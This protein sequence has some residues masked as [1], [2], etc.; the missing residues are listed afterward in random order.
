MENEN[1]DGKNG[2]K[3]TPT[4]QEAISDAAKANVNAVV[5]VARSAVTSF[6]DVL[7]GERKPRKGKRGSTRKKAKS[8]EPVRKRGK[9]KRSK[10]TRK[11]AA[12]R[13][14]A[15]RASTS[16]KSSAGAPRRSTR[17]AAGSKR[18]GRGAQAKQSNSGSRTSKTRGGSTKRRSR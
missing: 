5:E 2:G 13:G 8:R 15:K 7:T 14:K 4:A 11:P 10:A 3:L 16:R 17:K 9:S 12:M 18:T 1:D 6:V